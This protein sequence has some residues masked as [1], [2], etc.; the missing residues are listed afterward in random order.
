MCIRDSRDIAENVLAEQEKRNAVPVVTELLPLS[1]FYP[2]EEYHQDY[3]DKNPG[4]YCH[5]N[6]NSA[7]AVSYTHL[8]DAHIGNAGLDAR[9][10]LCHAFFA[11]PVEERKMVWVEI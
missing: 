7:D 5:I 10:F 3:L 11:M 4:G 8:K 2:A 1:N 9:H 6:L